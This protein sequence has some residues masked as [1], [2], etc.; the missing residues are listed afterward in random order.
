MYV[1]VTR[2]REMLFLSRALSRAS[3]G[4]AVPRTPSRFLLDVPPDLLDVFE[5]KDETP[6]SAGETVA[7][8]EAILAMLGPTR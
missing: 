6:T 2:A 4:K 5:V 1:G 3:R 8:I 7:N